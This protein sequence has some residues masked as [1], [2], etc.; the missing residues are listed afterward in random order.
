MTAYIDTP[1]DALEIGQTWVSGGRTMT[2]ADVVNF[3]MLVVLVLLA[4]HFDLETNRIPDEDRRQETNFIDAVEGDGDRRRVLGQ[5]G[6]DREDQASLHQP[7]TEPR[8][9]A[10]VGVGV[11]FE[12]VP[13]QHAEIDDVR[14]GHG[15]AAGYPGLP[16]LERVEG[17]IDI[18]RFEVEV[19]GKQ[20]KDDKYGVGKFRTRSINQRGEATMLCESALLMHR[21]RFEPD[22]AAAS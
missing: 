22:R 13:G 5:A 4:D 19:I 17:R 6:H 7:L 3:C 10:V 16:D 18:V 1:F 21:Q 11:N 14:L 15:A 12:P 20:D 9:L 8:I 2:E